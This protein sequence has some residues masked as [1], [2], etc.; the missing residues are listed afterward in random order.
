MGDLGEF[1]EFVRLVF[2]HDDPRWMWEDD[3]EAWTIEDDSAKAVAFLTFAFRNTRLLLESYSSE[4]VSV[5][6]A[7]L[8]NNSLSNIPFCLLDEQ[9]PL[10]DRLACLRSIELIYREFFAFVIPPGLTS[11]QAK[12]EASDVCFMFWDVFPFHSRTKNPYT[13]KDRDVVRRWDEHLQI[14]RTCI[15]VLEWTLA[16]RHTAC[17][18]AA[19]HG[20]GHWH[21]GDERRVEGII[22]DW[23]KRVPADHVLRPYAKQARRG[24]VL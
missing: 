11:D 12:T 14:E 20:L 22:D 1:E 21:Y 18:E 8:T 15:D 2:D 19:L 6:I 17:E 9:V 5:G 13:M 10:S 3:H 16:I 7:Y 24:M 4:Q 23:L